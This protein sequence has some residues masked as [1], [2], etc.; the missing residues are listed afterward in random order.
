VGEVQ[1]Y[2]YEL[3]VVPRQL[4]KKKPATRIQIETH[5]SWFPFC[6]VSSGIFF[7]PVEMTSCS[8]LFGILE[9]PY[10]VLASYFLEDVF[11]MFSLSDFI[12]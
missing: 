4:K 8:C 9:C 5:R 1:P 7:L 10:F 11:T 6:G 2:E 12:F 3:T